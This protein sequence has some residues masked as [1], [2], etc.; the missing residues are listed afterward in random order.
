MQQVSGSV[1]GRS[2]GDTA[3]YHQIKMADSE[4]QEFA[5]NGIHV[6]CDFLFVSTGRILKKTGKTR[7]D[8][9]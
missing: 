9:K 7:Y 4:G 8:E 2:L 1:R 3:S 5:E 6:G